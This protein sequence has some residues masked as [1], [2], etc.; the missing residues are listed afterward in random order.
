MYKLFS[1]AKE[2]LKMQ[3]NVSDNIQM[4]RTVD[5]LNKYAGTNY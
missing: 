4:K 5:I 3:L 1:A 2:G